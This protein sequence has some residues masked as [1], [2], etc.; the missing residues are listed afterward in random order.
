VRVINEN[1]DFNLINLSYPR[2]RGRVVVLVWTTGS[3]ISWF[4][5]IV[6]ELGCNGAGRWP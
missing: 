2:D 1:E 4:S 5:I 6:Y 3:A